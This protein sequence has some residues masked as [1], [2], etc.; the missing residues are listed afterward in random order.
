M[1]AYVYT[2]IRAHRS[3]QL[4]SSFQQKIC[5]NECIENLKSIDSVR[6]DLNRI[7]K[8]VSI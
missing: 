2:Y 6:P 8:C 1:Y 5:G 7:Q 3:I 4:G